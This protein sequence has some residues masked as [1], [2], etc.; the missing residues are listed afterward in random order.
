[1]KTIARITCV[2]SL[3]SAGATNVY[4]GWP[5]LHQEMHVDRLR[6]NA[7]PQPFRGIDAAAVVSPFEIQKANGWRQFNTIGATFFDEKCALNRCGRRED[8]GHSEQD[9]FQSKSALCLEGHITGRKQLN[10]SKP[11][12]SPF[13][14]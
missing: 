14:R 2:L 11:F 7:W 8:R 9:T 4:S 1:M 6:N 3:L 12:R 10:A 13:R 5:E